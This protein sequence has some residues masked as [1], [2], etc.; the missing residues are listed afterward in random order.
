[1][2]AI[3]ILMPVYKTEKFVT[4]SIKSILRQ[5]FTDW[6]LIIVDDGSPD[7]SGAICD[8][9]A[10]QDIRI[11]VIHQQNGGLACARQTAIDNAC[12]EY[13]IH[14]DSDDWCELEMLE[15]LYNTA[16]KNDADVVFCDYIVDYGKYKKYVKTGPYP[17]NHVSILKKLIVESNGFVWNKLVRRDC[18]YYPHEISWIKGQNVFEDMIF[19]IKLMSHPRKTAYKP[20]AY[21]HYVQN[22]N[23]NSYMRHTSMQPQ[24][25]RLNKILPDILDADVYSNELLLL[26]KKEAYEALVDKN[27]PIDRFLQEYDFLKHTRI[28]WFGENDLMNALHGNPKLVRFKILTDR[29]I[30]G[31]IKKIVR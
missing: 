2:P 25:E 6:E 30:R 17:E 7:N 28:D 18:Y 20:K 4:K 23:E 22:L 24:F 26:Q 3:S 10:K 19:S 1:M 9:F 29:Y 13:V 11:K 15:D 5:T 12:G 16:K 31:I 27:Y 14:V 21:Y 8:S